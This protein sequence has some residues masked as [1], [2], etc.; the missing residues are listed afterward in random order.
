MK[1]FNIT[2]DT[3][4]LK[5]FLQQKHDNF[6][7]EYCR[8]MEKLFDKLRHETWGGVTA[9]AP[10]YATAPI[11]EKSGSLRNPVLQ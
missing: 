8:K 5:A 1:L 6:L 10:L 3:C 4:S 9:P 2:L 11:F 7:W